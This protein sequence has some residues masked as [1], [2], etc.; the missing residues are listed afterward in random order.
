MTGCSFPKSTWMLVALLL[1]WNKLCLILQ[2]ET[3][4]YLLRSFTNF[5][6]LVAGPNPNGG[7]FGP[8]FLQETMQKLFAFP[9]SDSNSN[10]RK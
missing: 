10:V 3:K 8:D 2:S 9:P 6:H 5:C 7:Q 4:S 1:L